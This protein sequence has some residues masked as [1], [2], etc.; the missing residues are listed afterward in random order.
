MLE[1]T[2]KAI[3]SSV[4]SSVKG[5]VNTEDKILDYFKENPKTTIKEIAQYL[6]LS[7]RAIEKQIAKL[8]KAGKL[9]RVGS[10]RT[11]YWEVLGVN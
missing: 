10:A 3:K 5:S 8:K 9:Q 7:A 2:Y 6:G 4:K 11:G 1:I